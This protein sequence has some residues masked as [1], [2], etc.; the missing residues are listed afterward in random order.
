MVISH[1]FINESRCF[2]RRRIR[3]ILAIT[4][5]ENGILFSYFVCELH[6]VLGSGPNVIFSIKSV[7]TPKQHVVDS[8]FVHQSGL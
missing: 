2:L 6:S 3:V 1:K 7:I 4:N 5:D 8:T